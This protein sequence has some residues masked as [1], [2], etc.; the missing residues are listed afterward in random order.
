MDQLP[1][2]LPIVFIATTFLTVVLFVL[3]VKGALRKLSVWVFLMLVASLHG[4]LAFNGFYKD[5]SGTPPTI[6]KFGIFPWLVLMGLY[7][8]FA[9]KVLVARD[10][11]LR[12]LTLVHIVRIPVEIVLYVLA[13][14]QTVPEA[15]TFAG[16]NFDIVTGILSP[17]LFV[18]GFSGGKPRRW[19]LV[20]YNIGGLLLLANV[21]SIAILSL[22]MRGQMH[23]I[24]GANRAV[25]E[26]PY[27]W[28]PTIIVPIVLF[29]HVAALYK[30]IF[31]EQ[32]REE[33]RL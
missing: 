30:L 10:L 24:G 12:A 22:P 6:L 33:A 27:I 13:S 14:A 8:V 31:P 15:M 2:Y 26:F 17:I 28:L 32:L 18:L 16:R 7:F 1:G 20:F 11:S 21:V 5:T 3:S 29:S 19:L 25:L 9:R 23:S 4:W